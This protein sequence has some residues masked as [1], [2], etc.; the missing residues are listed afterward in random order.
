MRVA[1]R[2]DEDGGPVI[3]L[4]EAEKQIYA[5]DGWKIA[6]FE[7]SVLVEF[8][9]PRSAPE[10]EDMAARKKEAVNDAFT[11]MAS[12][13]GEHW[14]VLCSGFLLRNPRLIA[15]NDALAL[16]QMARVFSETLDNPHP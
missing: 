15:L 14:L 3:R 13:D 4:S 7:D 16:A 1:D 2:I 10:Q 9:D 5:S 6:R 8:F 11:W 12:T